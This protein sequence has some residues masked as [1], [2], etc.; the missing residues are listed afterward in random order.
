MI[1]RRDRPSGEEDPR[2]TSLRDTMVAAQI[3]RRGIRDTRVLD[4][5]RHVFRHTFIPGTSLDEAY[6]DHPVPIGHGQTV[7]Q[8]YMVA[9]MIEHLDPQPT[10]RVLE[11]GTGSGYQTAIL[12]ELAGEVWSVEIVPELLDEA[13]DRLNRLGAANIH[14]LR[15]DGSAGY[16]AAAP[17]DGIIV[18]AAAPRVP[19]PLTDQL[20]IG[21]RLVIPVGSRGSQMLEVVTRE[22]DGTRKRDVC[23]CIFVPLL[24]EH[25]WD[26]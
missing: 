26:A 5:M 22:K 10:D 4:A 12:A 17:Y 8:P 11:I 2:A 16:A 24:G 20:A 7:S 3:E 25:G 23:G 14:L 1:V 15:T 18:S 6:G 21:G 9:L 19:E 13:R